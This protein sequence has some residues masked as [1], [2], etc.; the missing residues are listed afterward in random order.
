MDST[1]PDIVPEELQDTTAL[2]VMPATD[3]TK[4]K[5]QPGGSS[6]GIAYKVDRL[7]HALEL[8]LPKTRG[9]MHDDRRSFEDGQPPG[10]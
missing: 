7:A 1:Q 9:V 3:T 6:G 8:T 4:G 5:P 2:G 10:E